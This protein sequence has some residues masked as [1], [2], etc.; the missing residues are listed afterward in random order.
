MNKYMPSPKK[1]AS[2][3]HLDGRGSVFSG[4]HVAEL[5]RRLWGLEMLMF[6]SSIPWI[7]TF[8]TMV[9][10]WPLKKFWIHAI[11]FLSVQPQSG[12]TVPL[13]VLKRKLTI[14]HDVPLATDSWNRC[15]YLCQTGSVQRICEHRELGWKAGDLGVYGNPFWAARTAQMSPSEGAE[16]QVCT[17]WQMQQ[18]EKTRRTQTAERN[19]SAWHLPKR[20]TWVLLFSSWFE[21]LFLPCYP[22]PPEVGGSRAVGP[23]IPAQ[24][25]DLTA[26]EE[27]GQD[28]IWR[29]RCCPEENGGGG[30]GCEAGWSS[31]S[32]VKESVLKRTPITGNMAN[33]TWKRSK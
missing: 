25:L 1:Q 22:R 24:V 18:R 9:T 10:F 20:F 27:Q 28:L 6:P 13:T 11:I 32:K 17:A 30:G 15:G 3:R 33:L 8:F 19:Q 2:K 7:N 26:G 4:N 23:P 16:M 5:P 31:K 12:D 21:R 29:Q 14:Q